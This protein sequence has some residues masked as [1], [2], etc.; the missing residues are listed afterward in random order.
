MIIFAGYDSAIDE[1]VEN[2]Y[3]D[4]YNN[5]YMEEIN[6]FYLDD[7]ETAQSNTASDDPGH[8]SKFNN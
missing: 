4:Q 2:N 1:V 5:Q 7:D 3:N 6:A 8:N